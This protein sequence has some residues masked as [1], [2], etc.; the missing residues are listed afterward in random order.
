MKLPGKTAYPMIALFICSVTVV[1]VNT[2]HADTFGR[3]FTTPEQR[4]VLDKM[5]RHPHHKQVK[6]K[7]AEDAV[8]ARKGPGINGVVVRED[9]KNTVWV[10]G[11]SNYKTNIPEAGVEIVS[12]N[13]KSDPVTGKISDSYKVKK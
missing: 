6:N 9:G 3:F 4:A 10:N 7:P 1:L 2:A 11:K 8:F 12:Q 5:R 13:I